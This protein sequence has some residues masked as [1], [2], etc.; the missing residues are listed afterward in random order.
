MRNTQYSQHTMSRRTRTLLAGAAVLM[1]ALIWGIT[2][3]RHTDAPPSLPTRIK[4]SIPADGLYR[5]A[6]A[7][8]EAAGVVVV[9][10]PEDGACEHRGADGICGHGATGAGWQVQYR[11][12]SV[13]CLR[14]PDG[15]LLFWGQAERTQYSAAAAYWLEQGK[16]GCP[17]PREQN[18][19]PQD[20]ASPLTVTTYLLTL[21]EQ[22]LYNPRLPADADPWLWQPIYAGQALTVPF[23]LPGLVPLGTATAALHVHLWASS[24]IP[25]LAPD[26]HLELHLNDHRV[27]DALFDGRGRWVITATVPARLLRQT[28]NE[29]VLQAPGDTGARVEQVLLD[30]I[31]L[32]Y[33]RQLQ[34]TEGRL[35]FSAPTSLTRPLQ[36]SGLP[37]TD[38]VL[39][40]V[41]D[42]WQPRQLVGF[43][44][45]PAKGAD[46]H[47]LTFTAVAGHR[48]VLVSGDGFWKPSAISTPAEED[49]RAR[50]AEADY[51]IVAPR[52]FLPAL[53]PLA[54]WREKQRLRVR[55][56]PLD[57][58]YE[59]FDEGRAGPDALRALLRYAVAGSLRYVLLAGDTSYDPLGY[60]GDPGPQ[61]PTCFV[62][63][64]H[65]G[66]TASDYCFADPDDDLVPELA[67]GR[68]PAD[69][70][71]QLRRMVAKTIVYE[72]AVDSNWRRRVLLIADGESEYHDFSDRLATDFLSPRGL[73]IQRV[74]LRVDQTEYTR[75]QE[76]IIRLMNDGVGVVDFAGHG[77][78][79]VWGKQ[80]LFEGKDV[81]RLHNRARYPILTALTC[82]TGFFQHPNV[83]SLAEQLLW[84]REAGV[85]AAFVPSSEGVTREQAP[86]VEAFY[87]WLLLEDALTLGDAV[88]AATSEL[89]AA[90]A[91]TPEMIKTYNL[92]GDPAL[93][94]GFSLL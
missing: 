93:R 4:L 70:P 75:E 65:F 89:V 83:P 39:W 90:R 92:L 28:G 26:H 38:V 8:L 80:P 86:V 25:D 91:T 46:S 16:G 87:R 20:A 7:D 11:G 69:S 63:T 47:Q 1:A 79:D 49:L 82:L 30:R 21:E 42:P 64:G 88:R 60:Q 62:H 6:P 53:E 43:A 10:R 12:R 85:V 61:L 14:Q 37:S 66:W 45:I 3:L 22:R 52:A 33:P 51:L 17:T 57:A 44:L 2:A 29:L 94:N 15:S 71:E 19:S 77:S 72:Q 74:Y 58:V 31:G 13:P 24:A 41:T 32:A 78:L 67:V 84:A 48:Y 18:V 35:L 9:S 59:Q 40:D 68:L 56:A 55:V 5:I 23:D 81:E 36:V 54:Q 73:T 76:E 50:V 27:A 34:A